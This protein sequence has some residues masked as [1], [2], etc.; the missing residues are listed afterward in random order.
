M[1]KCVL[2]LCSK[3]SFLNITLCVDWPLVWHELV[4]TAIGMVHVLFMY[5][6]LHTTERMCLVLSSIL[7]YLRNTKFL[8]ISGVICIFLES[9]IL[10][11]WTYRNNLQISRVTLSALNFTGLIVMVSLHPVT[12]MHVSGW[13]WDHAWGC[14]L[15]GLTDRHCVIVFI[16]CTSLSR[17]APLSCVAL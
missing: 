8:C 16:G 1:S 3:I 10:Y 12:Y 5:L 7:C 17:A 4:P 11:L 13:V 9:G 15:G 14:A 6:F 2:V